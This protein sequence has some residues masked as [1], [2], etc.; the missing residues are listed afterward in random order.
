MVIWLEKAMLERM[1]SLLNRQ[2]E[3]YQSLVEMSDRKQ[4]VLVKGDLKELESIIKAEQALL[5]QAGKLEESRLALQ[6]E[7]ASAAGLKPEELNLSKL[8]ELAGEPFASRYRA[9]QGC[10][11]GLMDQ[12][13]A[14]NKL[15]MELIEQSLSYINF[16][17]ELLSGAE[18]GDTYTPAGKSPSRKVGTKLLDRK[19]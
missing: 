6:G 17:L 9:L 1:E 7:M 5:W 12:L 13:G 19:V 8:A 16:S 18:A 3:L 11:V 14:I 4:Q 10:M 2:M 15:N